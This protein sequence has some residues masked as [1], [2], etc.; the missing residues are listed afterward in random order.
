VTDAPWDGS[1]S[2]WD[3]AVG[4]CAACLIDTNQGTKTKT[5]CSLPVR[6]PNG[7]INRNACHAAAAALAGA[8]GASIPADQKQAAARALIQIYRQDLNEDP[9]DDLV[10]LAGNG[11]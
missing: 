1:A 10:A 5:S 4:Y 8:R 11:K 2:R 7:T 6:E 9:S 3:S